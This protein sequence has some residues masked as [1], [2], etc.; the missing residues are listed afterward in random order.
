MQNKLTVGEYIIY[1]KN[2]IKD[3]YKNVWLWNELPIE[4]SNKIDYNNIINFNSCDIVCQL[5]DNTIIFTQC[6][7]YSNT[8]DII[9]IAK[10]YNFINETGYNGIIYYSN[11][12]FKEIITHKNNID[13]IN[14]PYIK[15]DDDFEVLTKQIRSDSSIISFLLSSLDYNKIIIFTAPLIV[16]IMI[17]SM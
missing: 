11:K 15:K 3:K 16:N 14:L 1:V 8:I 17:S 4:I 9:D 12:L 2:S 10:F 7:N 13:Y 6:K 5:Y